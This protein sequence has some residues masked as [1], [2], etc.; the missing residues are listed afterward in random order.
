[1]ASDD[2]SRKRAQLLR[3]N[4]TVAEKNLWF[5]LRN[6]NLGVK[7]RRQVPLSNYIVDFVCMEKRL[8]IEVDGGQHQEN[9]AYDQKRTTELEAMGFKVIRFWNNEILQQIDSV[10]SCI[11]NYLK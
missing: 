2:V 11:F 8:I 9:L 6:N 5:N 1:M 4:S 3:K 7:F 10:M